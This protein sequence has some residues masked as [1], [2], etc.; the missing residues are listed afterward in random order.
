MKVRL[1][2]DPDH[3]VELVRVVKDYIG[4]GKRVMAD[5]YWGYSPEEAI[6]LTE[7]LKPHGL[8]FFEEPCPQYDVDGL[9]RLAER[10]L[11]VRIAGGERIYSP[12]QYRHLA[13]RGAIHVFQPDASLCGGILACLDVMAVRA[14]SVQSSPCAPS[15][16]SSRTA[17]TTA[18]RSSRSVASTQP[19]LRAGCVSTTSRHPSTNTWDP[20]AP[21]SPSC[22]RSATARPGR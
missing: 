11:P 12:A 18:R 20:T 8:Y 17:P 10:A 5:A 9:A 2:K 6:A 4:P 13:Q 3:D 16:R 14:R 7:R 1:G 19:M 15:P 21:R 22:S